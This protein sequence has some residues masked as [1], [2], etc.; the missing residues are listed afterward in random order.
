M[1]LNERLSKKYQ[2]LFFSPKDISVRAKGNFL[3]LTARKT[4]FKED[5]EKRSNIS[6]Q[7][8]IFPSNAKLRDTYK[9]MVNVQDFAADEI[10]IKTDENILTVEAQKEEKSQRG[11]RIS[12][13]SFSQS[14]TLPP[15]V[16]P[17]TVKSTLTKAGILT[18]KAPLNNR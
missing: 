10:S 16:N 8:F 5:G 4:I 1:S 13:K 11:Q 18:I 7:K 17:E 14:F 9:I 15:S 6:E 12:T 2:I 3:F